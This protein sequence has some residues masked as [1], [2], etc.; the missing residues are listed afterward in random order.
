M[1]WNTPSTST[2]LGLRFNEI[3]KSASNATHSNFSLDNLK[4]TNQSE[5]QT[6]ILEVE[7]KS[8]FNSDTK[9]PF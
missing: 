4:M 8:I 2:G 5:V 1:M 6:F 3:I 9:L 7:D